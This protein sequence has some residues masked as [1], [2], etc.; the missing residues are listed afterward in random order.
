MRFS[1]AISLVLIASGCTLILDA[2]RHQTGGDG[3][4]PPRDSGPVDAAGRDAGPDGGNCDR[5]GDGYPSMDCGGTDCDDNN[6]NRYPNAIPICGNGQ[7]EGCPGDT[8]VPAAFFGGVSGGVLQPPLVLRSGATYGTLDVG[9]F[10]QAGGGLGTGVVVLTEDMGSGMRAARMDVPLDDPRRAGDVAL[11]GIAADQTIT[12]VSLEGSGTTRMLAVL[13]HDGFLR[14]AFFD[15]VAGDEMFRMRNETGLMPP[16]VST[17]GGR[18]WR[19]QEATRTINFVTDYG[20]AYFVNYEG[21]EVP[22]GYLRS[23]SAG[24][25]VMMQIA[26][27]L[28]FWTFDNV[29]PR[30]LSP[31]G[32]VSG[33]AGFDA[34]PGGGFFAAWPR[35]G[36]VEVSR[37]DCGSGVCVLP[38][39]LPGSE[40]VVRTGAP[41]AEVPDIAALANDTSVLLIVEHLEGR[42]V[43]SI[44]PVA[45]DAAAIAAPR[46][47]VLILEGN[48]VT[49][50]RLALVETATGTSVFAVALAAPMAGAP[51]NVVT[52]SGLRV[53]EAD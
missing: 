3:G 17:G 48:V 40:V 30:P 9:T 41:S 5:D 16:A 12:G 13:S 22:T 4:S 25:H 53:C 19:Q 32:G 34:F 1:V 15:A 44:Q 50:A 23:F 28:M 47:P 11:M 35:G 36:D 45:A 37:L 29:P 20:A 49:D 51:A 46:I 43:V 33:M 21:S 39:R 14:D 24:S 52:F 10:D 26:N 42:D 7:P 6:R 8:G 31:S 2:G 38:A 27:D 18:V